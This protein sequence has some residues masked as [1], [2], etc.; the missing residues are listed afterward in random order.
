MTADLSKLPPPDVVAPVDYETELAALKADFTARWPEF[1]ADLESEPVVKLLEL[2][3]YLKALLVQ[4]VND[5]SRANMLATSTGTDLDNLAALLGVERLVVDAGDPDARPPVAPTLEPDDDLR[6]RAAMALEGYP[7][8]GS[9]GA[10]R[11]HGLSADGQ[12]A[13][14]AVSSPTPGA[15]RVAVLAR[16]G[17]GTPDAALLAAVEGHLTADHIRPLTDTVQVVAAAVTAYAVEAHLHIEPGP[18]PETVRRAAEAAVQ[19]YV[20]DRRRLGA[21]VAVS[22][23]AAALH[24]PGVRRVEI[25]SPAADIAPGPDGAG[26]CTGITLTS[27]VVS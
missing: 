5:A 22:G 26:H 6:R 18:D 2:A 4:H 14:V 16:A 20:D 23:I 3:A 27:E 9:T 19:S 10:Y 21:Y 11:F 8:A 24:Q 25:A 12:V 15:V 17:G 1:N 13:D 7:T